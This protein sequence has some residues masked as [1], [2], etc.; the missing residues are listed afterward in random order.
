MT[1]ATLS[2]IDFPLIVSYVIWLLIVYV[3]SCDRSREADVGFERTYTYAGDRR[4][5]KKTCCVKLHVSWNAHYISVAC[6]LI[7]TFTYFGHF[8]FISMDLFSIHPFS[9][10]FSS[11]AFRTCSSLVQIAMVM[12]IVTRYKYL[13]LRPNRISKVDANVNAIQISTCSEFRLCWART[14]FTKHTISN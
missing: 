7:H 13:R 6:S 4:W 10:Q 1:A 3:N 8:F 12:M 5:K 9:A 14:Y 11:S 2:V